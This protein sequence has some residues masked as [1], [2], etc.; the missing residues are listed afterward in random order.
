MSEP[1]LSLRE[2]LARL[3]TI[4]KALRVSLDTIEPK[5]PKIV[6]HDL[7]AVCERLFVLSHVFLDLAKN[8]NEAAHRILRYS[9]DER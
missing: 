4:Q 8:A 6:A 3:E 1:E 5:Q 7:V 2:Q 9:G